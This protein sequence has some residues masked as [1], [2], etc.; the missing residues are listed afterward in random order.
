MPEIFRASVTYVQIL[1]PLKLNKEY[2][3]SV[4][5]Q[6]AD[7]LK[8]FIRVSVQF[9][10]K[11]IYS[12]LITAIH[13]K[14]P[15]TSAEIKPLLAILDESPVVTPEQYTLWQWIA[16]YY[17]CTTG[18]VMAAALPAAL[19]LSSETMLSTTCGADFVSDDET[20]SMLVKIVSVR[21]QIRY[22]DI[23]RTLT[24]NPTGKALRELI[25]EG[26][27]VTGESLRARITIKSKEYVGIAPAW[28]SEEKMN[29]AL[30]SLNRAPRQ[31]AFLTDL[32]SLLNFGQNRQ[33]I[34]EVSDIKKNIPDG[35]ASLQALLAKGVLCRAAQ[36]DESDIKANRGGIPHNP[37]TAAQQKAFAEVTSHFLSKDTVLLHGVTSS[38]KTELYIHLISHYL[39]LGRQVLYLLPEIALTTQIIQ[40]LSEVF[41]SQVVVYHS[42]FSDRERLRIWD[43]MSGNSSSQPM[44]V[45]GVRAAIFLP[46]KCLGLII[47]DEE[48]ENTFKQ[49]DPSPRYHARDTAI[50][51]AKQYQAKVLL[52]TATPSAESYYNAQT[53]KYGLVRLL[54]RYKDIQLPT[55][56]V[57]DKRLAH[58]RR[59]MV[60]MFS[61]TLLAAIRETLDS[62]RQVILFQNRRGFAPYVECEECGHIPACKH[63]DVSLTYHK[64][65]NRLVC[66]YCGY[67]QTLQPVCHQCKE[68]RV[69]TRGFGTEKIDEEIK[70]FFPE[71]T[72]GRLDLDTTRNLKSYEKIISD[73]AEGKSNILVGT[74]M[75]TK[76]LDFKNVAL[77]GI[78]N[79]DAMLSFPD[80][81]AHERSFQLMVQVAGRAGR[82]DKQGKVIIQSSDPENAVIQYVMQH[83]VDGFM[84][85]Q[86]AERRQ[87]GYP[88]Y[89]RLIK[90]TLR[91]TDKAL[92]QQAAKY[93]AG[94]LVPHF[95]RQVLGP[96]EPLIARI[97]RYFLQEMLLKIARDMPFYQ[98]LSTIA[99]TIDNIRN[100]ESFRRV[101]VYADVDPY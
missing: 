61:E 98:A 4:P 60:G 85:H 42:K 7:K 34:I 93:L 77:V 54:Q 91:H 27:I 26:V 11:R 16:G 92:T 51:L 96:H 52:G 32:L 35:S 13:D 75:L 81:R 100:H 90:I 10:K 44:V 28:Q 19:R 8:L 57:V 74:Q 63:C 21:G 83:D 31:L 53:G 3:F 47:V 37:L 66:H 45:L 18:E 87:F 15:E 97:Q 94:L 73:F 70:A 33:S 49:Y 12:G 38:G 78:I 6:W 50:V 40:R 80:F 43:A 59:Q 71:T 46:F 17:Q 62:G 20:K 64:A 29:Q 67:V 72:V 99:Q 2:T 69:I 95:G 89:N 14:A 25:S 41:G 23:L 82:F 39:S 84:H 68:P 9:G 48:H 79:A 65:G 88:P 56:V 58:K 86:L 1:L 36:S 30:D 5:A 101:D 24:D 55:V 76:G 22:S